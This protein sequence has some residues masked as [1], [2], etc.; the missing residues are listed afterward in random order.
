MKAQSFLNCCNKK[1]LKESFFY[2]KK[3]K[4]ETDFNIKNYRRK[5]KKC[6]N[7]N[8]MFSYFNFN[9]KNL[10]K[11][12]YSSS[13]YG[14]INKIK[15]NFDKIISLPKKKSDNKNRVYR[16]IKYINKNDK[17]LDIGSG[18]GVF[19]YELSNMGF[20]VRGIEPDQ[21]LFKHSSSILKKK[22]FKFFN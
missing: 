22:N 4:G 6:K 11:K 20:K 8:H 3:P 15:K 21:N 16:C 13:A 9:L 18:L 5:F 1:K 19:L 12:K 7:C 14:D 17:I 2:K 10:Y